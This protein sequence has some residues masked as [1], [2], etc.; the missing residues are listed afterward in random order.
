VEDTAFSPFNLAYP[1]LAKPIYT[2][3]RAYHTA[4]FLP[5]IVYQ[6]GA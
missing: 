4:K 3:H 1:C 2:A 5:E 6:G